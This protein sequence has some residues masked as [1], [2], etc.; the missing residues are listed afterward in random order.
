MTTSKQSLI[1]RMTRQ[2]KEEYLHLLEIQ[3][4]RYAKKSLVE[5]SVRNGFIPAKHHQLIIDYLEK[6]ERGDIQNLLIQTPPGAAKSTYASMMFPS[7][8]LG[9]NPKM[10]V[11][12]AS[13]TM[14]LAERF[15]R[16]VRGMV[17]SPDFKEIFGFG[18]STE[19]AAAGRWETEKGGE[20]FSVGVGGSVTGRRGDLIVI[21]DPIRGRED[22]DSTT[23]RDKL[24]DWYRH[25]LL[26]RIK[27][28]GKQV[29]A[30]T[31][32]HEDDIAGRILEREAEK[33]TTLKLEMINTREDDPL[34]RAVGET[35]WPEWFTMEMIERAQ[36]DPRGWSSLYQQN[37][38]PD[39]GGEFKKNWVEYYDN[40]PNLKNVA[41]II[42]VD[43]ANQL[44]KRA[45]YTA[46]WVIGVGGDENYYVLD[47]VRDRLNLADRVDT[48]FRLHRKWKARV[49]RYEKYG[50]QSDIDYIKIEM[51]RRS[52]RFKIQEV[53]GT[54]IK[55]EDRIRRLIPYFRDGKMIFPREF[56]YTETSGRT[57]D[58]VRVFIEEELAAFP[59][60]KH[61]DLLDSL[62]RLAEPGLV[63]PRFIPE[64]DRRAEMMALEGA[65][66]EPF[67]P[68]FA[69]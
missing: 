38:V 46:I 48:I 18:L 20:Y 2:E 13:H 28:G 5:F 10:N 32:W 51:D 36:Q 33:W 60:S 64:E 31:R 44:N 55:K 45:D 53:G 62:S 22:A 34:D 42:L 8:F 25:D 15:G 56:N 63:I 35:L 29:L 49:V 6:L 41:P 17:A 3:S 19:S 65:A 67:D 37:P 30:M 47:I 57:T 7:W 11:I 24:W 40:A 27:P 52:Y 69:Y 59:V 1:D 12:A 68:E 16:K 9:R 61:D 23:M 50:M 43:P 26:T 4:R 58:L 54:R 66:F 39:G 21:D 14:E